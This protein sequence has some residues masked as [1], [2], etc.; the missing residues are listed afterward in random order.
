MHGLDVRS[1]R[2]DLDGVAAAIASL[3]A[4]VVALQEVDRLLARSGAVDQTKALAE[5]L[6]YH[7]AFAPALL[8]S[9]DVAWHSLA[10]QDPG[11]EAYGVAL[12]SRGPLGTATPISL[13]GGGDGRRTT[14]ASP[15]N[16]GWDREPRVALRAEVRAGAT[17]LA[18]TTTHLSY[19][20]WR[21]LAQLHAA[22]AAA[23]ADVDTDGERAAVLVGD[24]NL[25]LWVVRAALPQWQHAGGAPTYPAWDPRLQVDQL[26]ARG[27]VRVA[28]VQVGA[29]GSSDHLPLL[30]DLEL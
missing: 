21:G 25:P 3:D 13:P 1:G 19:L 5:R 7:G 16:P 24:L 23:T 18:V 11:G 2:V 26:L 27:S 22:A 8:G 10:G 9:P 4:D 6:G 30:V 29:R 28:A 17:T 15:Q 20:P 14:A 12:L